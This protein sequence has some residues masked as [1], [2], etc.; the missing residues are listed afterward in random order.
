MPLKMDILESDRFFTNADYQINC[1]IYQDDETTAQDITGWSFSWFLKKRTRDDDANAVIAKTTGS[2]VSIIDA[3]TGYVRVTISDD[4]TDGLR[5]GTYVHELKRTGAGV[6]T[7]L[8]NGL[9][10]LRQSAHI[11]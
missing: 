8:V 9:A 5:A 2:G 1:R 4:D 7:P 6:E 10:V 3:V 11:L